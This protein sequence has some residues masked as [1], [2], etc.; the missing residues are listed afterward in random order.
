MHWLWRWLWRHL[1]LRAYPL[2]Y[3]PV[4][5]SSHQTLLFPDSKRLMQLTKLSILFA[6]FVTS[7]AA[8][9][10]DSD[11]D[12][13]NDD[14]ATTSDKTSDTT[15]DNTNDTTTEGDH[16][17]SPGACTPETRVGGF[18]LQITETFSGVGGKVQD[19]PHRIGPLGH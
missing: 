17:G 11:D 6:A 12:M 1:L 18:T 13:S 5:Q 8:S 9:A 14:N 10:C 16:Q 7:F 19:V 3:T 15:T 4:L 2:V